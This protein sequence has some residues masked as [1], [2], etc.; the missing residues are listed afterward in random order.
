M[1]SVAEYVGKV[2]RG[3]KIENKHIEISINLK[4]NLS[5]LQWKEV[6]NNYIEL[7]NSE[8]HF[9]LHILGDKDR[10]KFC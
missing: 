1:G 8:P 4:E 5:V 3:G 10:P 9:K 6:S 2:L 7:C